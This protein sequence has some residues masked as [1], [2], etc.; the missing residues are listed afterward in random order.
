AEEIFFGRVTTGAAS[1]LQ[2]ATRI[3][4]AMVMQYGMSA[5]LGL[6]TYGE[7]QGNIFLGREFGQNRD[8]SE[9]AA[10]LIDEEVRVI[11]DRNYG[12]AKEVITQNRA[13]LVRL[14]DKLIEVE[15]LD[16]E[17]FEELMNAPEPEVAVDQPVEVLL[18]GD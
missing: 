12:R 3:A 5:S 2:Q 1:D 15:T 6:R 13:Q 7:Q 17:Q 14:V 16:R 10:R 11:L 9:E 4:R 8:Y 18:P